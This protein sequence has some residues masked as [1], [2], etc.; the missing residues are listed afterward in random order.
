MFKNVIE[1]SATFKSL[2]VCQLLAC[3]VMLCGATF[4]AELVE[5]SGDWNVVG[6]ETVKGKHILLDGSLILPTG[7]KLTLE[8]CTLEIVGEYSRQHSVEWRGGTLV[9]K[10]CTIGGFVDSSGMAVH[11]VFHLYEGCWEATDT[12]VSYSYGIS[13]HWEK[14][15]G[16]L[17]GRGLKAGPRPD[18]IILSGEADVELVDSDFPIGLGVYCNK[19]GTTSL[20]LTPSESVTATFDRESLLPGVNW[21]LDLKD[22]R[23]ERWFLVPAA[24]WRMAAARGSHAGQIERRDRFVVHSQLEGRCD[25]YKRPGGTAEDWQPDLPAIDKTASRNLYVR[26]VPFRRRHR[27]HDSRADTH[28]RMDA[29]WRHGARSGD[30]PA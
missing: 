5:R 16:V 12:T 15:K 18:A 26:N 14:G 8:D 29:G 28:L 30:Q 17:R 3:T 25:T 6:N 4:S 1:I 11:T 24:H 19:G 7:A 20:N 13:F 21:R 27:R 9:T 23:V 10:N 2:L 22:T